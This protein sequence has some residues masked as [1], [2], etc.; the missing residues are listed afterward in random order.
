SDLTDREWSLIAPFMPMPRRLGR[1]RDRNESAKKEGAPLAMSIN[2]WV[3]T[4]TVIPRDSQNKETRKRFQHA[5]QDPNV[6]LETDG[7]NMM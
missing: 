5:A 6:R 3:N 1:P 7:R 4:A 2:H